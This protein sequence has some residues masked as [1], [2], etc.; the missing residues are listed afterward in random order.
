MLNISDLKEIEEYESHRVFNIDTDSTELTT[1][2]RKRRQHLRISRKELTKMLNVSDDTL[3]YW[4]RGN[5]PSVTLKLLLWMQLLSFDISAFLNYK[6]HVNDFSRFITRIPVVDSI[7]WKRGKV[8]IQYK[9]KDAEIEVFDMAPCEV[10][11]FEYYTFSFQYD[12]L[13]LEE[14]CNYIGFLP[15]MESLYDMEASCVL[16]KTHLEQVNDDFIKR[17]NNGFSFP[18]LLLHLKHK[19]IEEGSLVVKYFDEKF[20]YDVYDLANTPLKQN[21]FRI[22]Y[23]IK[24]RNPIDNLFSSNS[25]GEF[26]VHNKKVVLNYIP[27]P[28]RRK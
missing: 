12:Y 23:F 24:V 27:Y 10:N 8:V 9:R 15:N 4:E 7:T 2:L 28:N 26:N 11:P 21:T 25:N 17:Q 18:I 5:Y 22:L 6:F 1:L 19:Q 20:E 16:W 3:R 13:C 14:G